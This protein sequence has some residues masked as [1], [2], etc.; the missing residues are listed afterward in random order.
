MRS[1]LTYLSPWDFSPTVL[2]ACLVPAVLYVR[3]LRALGARGETVGFGAALTFL[4]G[5]TLDYVVL[6][7]YFDYLSQHMFWIHRLQHLILHHVGPVLLVLSAPGPVLS[8]GLP[9]G[10]LQRLRHSP[11]IRRPIEMVL[12]VVQ[13]PIVAPT[14]FVGLIY[15]WLT[16]SIHFAAMLDVQLYRLMNWSMLVDGILF[17]W[18]MLAPTQDHGRAA[19]ELSYPVRLVILAAVAVPQIVIGAYISLHSTSLYNVYALCGR[20]W[21]ISP[22]LDQQLGG[23]LTWIPPVMMSGIGVLWVLHLV[24]REAGGPATAVPLFPP[25]PNAMLESAPLQMGPAP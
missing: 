18:L 24:L 17:W 9:P 6:Q 23:L 12:R 5:L 11:W 25:A 4:I 19:T 14:L 1:I 7:T 10:A 8:A 21:A 22:M 13:N 2:I 16:P 15:F 3:G 20:A